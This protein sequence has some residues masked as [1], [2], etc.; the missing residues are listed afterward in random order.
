MKP[1]RLFLVIALVIC[2][3]LVVV[4]QLP[5]Q[6]PTKENQQSDPDRFEAAHGALLDSQDK[7]KEASRLTEQVAAALPNNVSSGP[8]PRKNFIDEHIFGRIE[9]DK[10]PHAPLAGDEEFLRRAYL[11]AVGDIP[12][13]DKIRSFVADKDPNKR[14]K[15]IDSLIGTEDFTNE[16]A[17]H[18][19]ELTRGRTSLYHIWTKMWLKVDRPYN[20]VVT[21][22]ITPASGDAGTFPT[23]QAFYN[24]IAYISKNCVALSNADDYKGLNRLDWIDEITSDI[25]RIFLGVNMDCFSCH[26][27]AGHADTFN[28]FMGSMKRTDFWKQAA[29]FGNLRPIAVTNNGQA[30]N[31]GS[32]ILDDLQPGYNTGDDGR[33]FT[34]ALG[35]FPRDGRAY[36]PA[37]FLTGEKPRPGEE[38][39]KALARM[40]TT[41]IQFARATVNFVWQRLMVIGLVEPYDGF[42]LLRLDPKNIPAGWTVQ[43]ANPELLQ[44]LAE[45]FRDNNYS[46]HHLIKT[47]MKSNT[48]QLS[49]SFPGQFKDAYIPYYARRFARVLNAAEIADVIAEATDT[50]YALVQNGKKLTKVKQLTDPFNLANRGGRGASDGEQKP[51]YSMMQAYFVQE[52]N[53]PPPEKNVATP[54]QAMVLMSSP[55]VAKRVAP[56]GTSRVANLVKSGKSDDEIVEE[57]F[58]ATLSRRPTADEVEVAKRLIAEDRKGGAESVQWALLNAAESLLN[59]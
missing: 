44:A 24:P 11:D 18:W 34:P 2:L 36:E 52:R 19:D 54:V 22:I 46:I 7:A 29:F 31:F 23:A 9:R 17:Y 20:D 13:P 5:Q 40:V 48:Y 6:D 50:P 56:E 12:S 27:G 4:A 25:G 16:W 53:L 15:L 10:I 14:D 37:F 49:T 41:H 32:S 33:F 59:H 42:D 43:P 3:S 1:A 45:D 47:I 8:I 35:R 39:R 58:L 26:N 51:L 38:P 57:L 30:V 55:L 21:E 28:L